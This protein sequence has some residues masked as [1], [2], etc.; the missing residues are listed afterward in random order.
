MNKLEEALRILKLLVEP[1]GGSI[2]SARSILSKNDHALTEEEAAKLKGLYTK[3]I[4]GFFYC[5]AQ[6]L[7]FT[8]ISK[9][10]EFYGLSL[11]DRYPGASLTFMKLARTYWT[12][13]VILI[14]ISSDTSACVNLLGVIDNSFAGVFF[15]TPGPFQPPKQLREKTMRILIEQSG[16]NLDV[17]DYIRGNFYL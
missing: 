4:D 12:F 8:N 7:T 9:I 5:A 16:A 15:P 3:A 14:N 10:K 1:A 11:E 17:E 2:E 6:D 13:K